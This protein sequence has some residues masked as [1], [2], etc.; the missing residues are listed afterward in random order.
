MTTAADYAKFLIHIMNGGGLSDN[1]YSEFL[2][3]QVNEK[4]GIDR[5][6]GMQLLSKLPNNEIALMHT[7]GDYGTK[8]IAIAFPNSKKGLVIFS[9]S[10]NGM[11]L[12]QKIISEYFGETGLEI[13][14]RNLE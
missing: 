2:K 11:V 8:T 6:L 5:N 13:V 9:N 4:N 12:W 10:E 7:G 14:R 3:P 1:L